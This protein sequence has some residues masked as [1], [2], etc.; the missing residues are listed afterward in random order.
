MSKVWVPKESGHDFSKA[1]KFG[2]VS[3]ILD[4]DTSPF[5]MDSLRMAFRK[6]FVHANENDYVLLSG[7][8]SVNIIMFD[9]WPFKVMNVLMFH[10]RTKEYIFREIHANT[11]ARK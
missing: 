8:A 4:G 3:V 1:K 7:P 11:T 5:N 9:E 6:A 10:A 2:D